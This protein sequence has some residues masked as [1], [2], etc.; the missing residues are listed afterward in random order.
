M[1]RSLSAT[2][3][4]RTCPH[5]V[6]RKAT[7]LAPRPWCWECIKARREAAKRAALTRLAN[8][9]NFGRSS[10]RG[11]GWPE[12]LRAPSRGTDHPRDTRATVYT[13]EGQIFDGQKRPVWIVGQL[14]YTK[15]RLLM[16]DEATAYAKAWFSGTPII[17]DGMDREPIGIAPEQAIDD[18]E[19]LEPY[20]PQIPMPKFRLMVTE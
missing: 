9:S 13:R 7:A 11:G 6:L 5:G 1:T 4:A 8:G 18:G 12:W 15:H 19:D 20:W 3:I 14:S 16:L 2:D 10:L 17:G